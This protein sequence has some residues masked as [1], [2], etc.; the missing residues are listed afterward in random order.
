M[1]PSQLPQCA[2][3]VFRLEVHPLWG[4]THGQVV[5]QPVEFLLLHRR[6]RTSSSAQAQAFSKDCAWFCN[7]KRHSPKPIDT[8]CF[9]SQLYK[10]VC[11]IRP[12][13]VWL[14]LVVSTVYKSHEPF[15]SYHSYHSINPMNHSALFYGLS[16]ISTVYSIVLYIQH[17]PQN[18]AASRGN[19]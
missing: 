6:C 8:G 7:W 9:F 12:H 18:S 1:Q 17:T 2:P 16:H 10:L 15:Y 5:H 4:P 13:K 11:F 19:N 14:S 3:P